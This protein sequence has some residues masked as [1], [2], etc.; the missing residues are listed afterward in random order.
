MKIKICGIP[1]E[2][3][4]VGDKFDADCHFGQ[5][6]YKEC[7]IYIN[8]DMTDEV[9]WEAIC[10]ECLHAML[11]HLGFNDQ[12]QDEHLVQALGNAI[13]QSFDLKVVKD[14]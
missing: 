7:K 11:V 9:K 10:H 3:I 2:I 14:D 8:K 5:I 13:Y 4:Q 6:N 12:A 1:H